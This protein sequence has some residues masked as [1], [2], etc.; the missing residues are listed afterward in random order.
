MLVWIGNLP[1]EIPFFLKRSAGGWWYVSAALIALHF[2]LP[3]L[4][5]LFRDIKL[6]PVRLRRVAI[7]LLVICAS[8]WSGIA[9]TQPH[10]T[11]RERL[12]VLLGHGHWGDPRHWRSLWSGVDLAVEEIPANP[13][14]PGLP[15]AGGTP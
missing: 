3:F 10:L 7:F 2:A 11:S 4:L 6:H 9:P 15:V 14:Q 8:T 13:G 12:P 5:L 1:E